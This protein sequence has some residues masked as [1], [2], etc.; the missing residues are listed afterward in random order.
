MRLAGGLGWSVGSLI[1]KIV[2]QLAVDSY[3]AALVIMVVLPLWLLLLVLLL[4]PSTNL[5]S[6]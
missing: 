2:L 3:A 1:V 5:L 4:L 6:N